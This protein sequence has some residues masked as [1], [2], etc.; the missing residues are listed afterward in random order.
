MN[1][2]GRYLLPEYRS[3]QN[4]ISRCYNVNLPCYKDYG[5]RGI[6]VCKRWRDSFENFFA[7]VGK[8]PSSKHSLDRFPHNNRGYKP[9]NVRWATCIEQSQNTRRNVALTFRGKTHCMSKWARIVGINYRTIR[10][11]LNRGWS[12]HDALT[13]TSRSYRKS[14]T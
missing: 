1:L 3:W 5:G 13:I 9:G 11:R 14:K 8:K 10:S 4:M 6:K 2:R 12:T 7:D